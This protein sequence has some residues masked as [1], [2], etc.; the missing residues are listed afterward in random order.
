M[1]VGNYIP[2]STQTFLYQNSSNEP[3]NLKYAAVKAKP[4]ESAFKNL[5]YSPNGRPGSKS[6]KT[7]SNL[8]STFSSNGVKGNLLMNSFKNSKQLTSYYSK[9]KKSESN[10]SASYNKRQ[11]NT[12]GNP[13]QRASTGSAKRKKAKDSPKT[14]LNAQTQGYSTSSSTTKFLAGSIGKK[15]GS[16]D[17]LFDSKTKFKPSLKV[18]AQ[19][20]P[21]KQSKNSSADNLF[22]KA[23]LDN[24]LK[25]S[26]KGIS[27]QLKIKKDKSKV[28]KNKNKQ[29]MGYLNKQLGIHGSSKPGN[30]EPLSINIVNTNHLH[31]S[32]YSNSIKQNNAHQHSGIETD[33]KENFQSIIKSF[34]PERSVP[35]SVPV[36]G[37]GV[38]SAK[39]K[40]YKQVKTTRPGYSNPKSRGKSNYKT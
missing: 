4:I 25:Y 18:K 29:E 1:M 15:Y 36:S 12:M 30:K 9:D 35:N 38:D 34:K 40:K 21:S 24:E 6:K 23:M 28:K 17:Y 26:Y 16:M 13:H 14:T 33:K 2:S 7:K 37:I 27:K 31:L 19:R 39:K 10:R 32:G 8:G 20:V 22:Q 5:V 3:T 11:Q